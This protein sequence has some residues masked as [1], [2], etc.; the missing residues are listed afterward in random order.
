MKNLS[1]NNKLAILGSILFLFSL[2]FEQ[3]GLGGVELAAE[4]CGGFCF[5][6]IFFN[7]NK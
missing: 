1:K 3:L 2:V 7:R 6:Q 5:G 4:F